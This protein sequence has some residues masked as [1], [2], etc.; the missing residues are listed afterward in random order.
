L[1]L[2]D[3]VSRVL[4]KTSWLLL[5]VW[6]PPGVKSIPGVSFLKLFRAWIAPGAV[7][8]TVRI[9]LPRNP[10]MGGDASIAP[11][12]DI[13]NVDWHRFVVAVMILGK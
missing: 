9:W 4:W 7:A 5:T 1:S 3:R 11:G 2:T 13:Y 6:T 12:V 10:E 8:A